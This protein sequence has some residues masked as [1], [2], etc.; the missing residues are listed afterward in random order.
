MNN[1]NKDFKWTN[2]NCCLKNHE[3]F[4]FLDSSVGFSKNADSSILSLSKSHSL[5]QL[6]SQPI[7]QLMV[8]SLLEHICNLHGGSDEEANLIFKSM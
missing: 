5:N 1:K 7:N 4:N 2:K 3:S 6:E 8:I